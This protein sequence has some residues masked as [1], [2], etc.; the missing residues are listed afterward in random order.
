VKLLRD[1][2]AI[3]SLPN[4]VG[5]HWTSVGTGDFYTYQDLQLFQ[6]GTNDYDN[7]HQMT[8]MPTYLLTFDHGRYVGP[9]TDHAYSWLQGQVDKTDPTL[10]HL[11]VHLIRN[12]KSAQPQF[13][14]RYANRRIT[15]IDSIPAD[16]VPVK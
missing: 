13:R 4:S 3:T 15:L 10:I 9:V 5:L 11:T 8:A 16:A 2:T 1:Q 12:G 14:A 7:N 6:A